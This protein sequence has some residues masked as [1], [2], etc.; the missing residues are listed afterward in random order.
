MLDVNQRPPSGRQSSIAQWIYQAMGMVGVRLQTRWRG[1]ELHILLESSRCLESEAIV[2]K[3]IQALKGADRETK[4]FFANPE[5]PIY[6]VFLYNRIAGKPQAEWIKSIYLHQ[7]DKQI[8]G[9]EHPVDTSAIGR[10]PALRAIAELPSPQN[11]ETTAPTDLYPNPNAPLPSSPP[12]EADTVTAE[13]AL[14][15]SSQSLARSGA[16]EAI[17]RYL[18]ETLSPLG[19]SVKVF[20]QTFPAQDSS[21][22]PERRLWAICDSD[23]SPDPSL[24]AEPIAQRLRDLQLTGFRD[25]A[26]KSQVTGEAAPEWLLRVDLTPTGEMLQDWGRWGDVQAIARLLNQALE[27]AGIEV[28]ASLKDA[29]LHLFCHSTNRGESPQKS[30][31]MPVITKLLQ[32]LA[33]QGI[34]AATIYGAISHQQKPL[35]IDWLN[36]PA[37]VHPDLAVPALELAQQGDQSALIFLLQRLLNPDLDWRLTTG[38]I[39]IQISRKQ[40]LLHVM[41]D[42]LVCP[43][44]NQVGSRIARFLQQLHLPAVAGVRIYGRCSGQSA[45][46]W[47]YGLDF[48]S[49][50]P[51]VETTPEFAPTDTWQERELP[52]ESPEDLLQIAEI[53]PERPDAVRQLLAGVGKTWQQWL[54][55]S[56]LFVPATEIRDLALRSSAQPVRKSGRQSQSMKV[57]V[58]WGI[59]GLLL[60]VQAD[61]LIHYLLRPQIPE[62]KVDLNLLPPTADLPPAELPKISLEK[63]KNPRSKV[64]NASRFTKESGSKVSDTGS[65][66][67]GFDRKWQRSPDFSF[68][69]PLLDQKLALYQHICN[70][71]GPPDVLIVGSSRAM[72]GIDPTAL[73][74]ALAVQGYHQPQIFNFG[75]NGATAQVVDLLLRR[76]LTPAQMP[77]LIIWADGARAF[78]SSRVDL[79][80][81]AIAASPGYKLLLAG[82]FH[83]TATKAKSVPVKKDPPVTGTISYQAVNSKL[84]QLIA[85]IS[86]AYPERHQFQ[87]LLREQFTNWTSPTSVAEPSPSTLPSP[88]QE[89]LTGEEEIELNGFFPLSMQFNP[90]NYYQQYAK[91]TGDYDSDYES[92]DMVGKQDIALASTLQ[93]L[94]TNKVNLVFVNMPLTKEYLDPVRMKYESQF[95]R[96]MQQISRNKGLV[97]RDLSQLWPS[98]NNFFSDPSHLN[99]YGAYEV[100]NQLAKDPTI[101]WPNS[102]K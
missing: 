36:L 39:R 83:P 78:N 41:T 44:K 64:F 100:S 89:D 98:K 67:K 23:Y 87:T 15:V 7:L 11:L 27:E 62:S 42:A 55:A 72:R 102:V 75:I 6:Q 59:V 81:N 1:N 40:D 35:W 90:P 46:L 61:W 14:V 3:F 25:A 54:C 77:K 24:L 45:P 57:A 22:P 96:N 58:V 29:T 85:A 9:L 82:T 63:T 50:S 97:F 34:Q 99:R 66:I 74:T 101:T 10:S 13:E 73:Q 33:P 18:S 79:T 60:V 19:V 93:F 65:Q 95:Q 56:H 37:A 68:N 88:Q 84:N 80:Y 86:L 20:I 43:P 17:A 28:A 26:I 31:A 49:R 5:R 30:L 48:V 12:T 16:P 91:V 70:T 4:A 2:T 71:S 94:Q 32:S 69:N 47:K 38:G 92:F 53:I 76:I 51:V 52:V 21:H 8:K